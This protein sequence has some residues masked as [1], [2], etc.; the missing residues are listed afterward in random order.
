METPAMFPTGNAIMNGGAVGSSNTGLPWL[1][2]ICAKTSWLIGNCLGGPVVP[3]VR[4]SMVGNGSDG[5]GSGLAAFMAVCA[6]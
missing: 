5:A 3:L 2:I 4:M 6:P 1:S